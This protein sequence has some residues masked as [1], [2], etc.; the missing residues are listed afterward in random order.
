M[1]IEL[2]TIAPRHKGE[3]DVNQQLATQ[4]DNS[5]YFWSSLDFIPGVNDIDLL[6]WHKDIGCFV[7]EI[8]AIPIDMLV[9][10]SF[11]TCEI[12]GRGID[13]SPQNQ[14]YDALQSLRNY[15]VP[16]LNKM[17]FMVAT[18]CWPLISRFEWNECFKHSL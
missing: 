8:K 14:A 3:K 5:L 11:S 13:R 18:V 1:G 16:L 7:V 6:I 10:F 17:P 12:S 9:S 2:S 4:E 15:L